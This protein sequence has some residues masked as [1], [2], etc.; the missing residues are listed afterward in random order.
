MRRQ[1]RFATYTSYTIYDF[2]RR[3]RLS[4]GYIIWRIGAISAEQGED[5]GGLAFFSSVRSLE[6]S[7]DWRINSINAIGRVR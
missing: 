4:E 3:C 5:F 7:F 2:I 1:I 6:F